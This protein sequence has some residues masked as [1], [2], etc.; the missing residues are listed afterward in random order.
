MAAAVEVVAAAGDKI[1]SFNIY[2]YTDFQRTLH[3]KTR[4]S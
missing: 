4:K 2:G 3:C 1:L